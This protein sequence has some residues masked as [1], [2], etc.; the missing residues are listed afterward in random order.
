MEEQHAQSLWHVAA[1]GLST[2]GKPRFTRVKTITFGKGKGKARTRWRKMKV[3]VDEVADAR[4]S[5]EVG[6]EY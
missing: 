2:V 3:E 5:E 4:E 1:P 6:D